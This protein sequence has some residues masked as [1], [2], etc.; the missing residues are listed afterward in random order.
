MSIVFLGQKQCFGIDNWDSDSYG[1]YR[2]YNAKSRDSDLRVL[3][4]NQ[5]IFK[6]MC[7]Q[8][9]QILQTL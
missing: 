7:E 3:V 9:P 5:K 2:K 4:M 8:N 6:Q 1:T